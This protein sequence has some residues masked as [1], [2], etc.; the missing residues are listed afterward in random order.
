MTTRPLEDAIVRAALARF[1]AMYDEHLPLIEHAVALED[2]LR[3][4]CREYRRRVPQ[5]GRPPAPR[6]HRPPAPET[7]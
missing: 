2:A 6:E 7:R 5:V 4:A 1:D 3:A